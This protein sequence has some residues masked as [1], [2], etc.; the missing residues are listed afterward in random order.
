MNRS[1]RIKQVATCLLL[2]QLVPPAKAIWRFAVEEQHAQFCVELLVDEAVEP[3]RKGEVALCRVINHQESRAF[4]SKAAGRQ[5]LDDGREIVGRNE[6]GD[7]S[8]FAYGVAV[9]CAAEFEGKSSLA[10][11]GTAEE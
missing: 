8:A 3:A 9:D 10:G 5:G 1:R 2:R 4:P 11:P 7:P 6:A